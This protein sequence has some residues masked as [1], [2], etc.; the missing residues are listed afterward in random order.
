MHFYTRQLPHCRCGKPA[1][2][3][4]L[5][6]GNVRYDFVCS[7]CERKRLRE[8]DRTHNPSERPARRGAQEGNS[9]A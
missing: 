6:T 8:L 4:V 1:S 9:D 3:E 5:G 7:G 2:Y